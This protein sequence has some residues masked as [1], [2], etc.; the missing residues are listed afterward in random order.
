[1]KIGPGL[2]KEATTCTTRATKTQKCG[3]TTS[4]R[5]TVCTPSGIIPGGKSKVYGRLSVAFAQNAMI[6]DIRL[7]F[8]MSAHTQSAS[9]FTRKSN[10]GNPDELWKDVHVRVLELLFNEVRLL[11]TSYSYTAEHVYNNS[12]WIPIRLR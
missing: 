7:L 9:V 6:S 8:R 12:S 4:P 10:S 3:E 2:F 5:R 1:M 11:P